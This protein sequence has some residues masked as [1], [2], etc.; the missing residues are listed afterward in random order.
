MSKKSKDKKITPGKK[1]AM[2]EIKVAESDFEQ[3]KI[4]FRASKN[5]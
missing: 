3:A 2:K 4:S 5:R 1:L